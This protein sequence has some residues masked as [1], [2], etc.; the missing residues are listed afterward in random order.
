MLTWPLIVES[1]RSEQ[2]R[3]LRIAHAIVRDI[4]RGRLKPGQRL[5]G[6]R[7]LAS[8]LKVHRNTVLAALEELKGQGWLTTSPWRGTFVSTEL[9]ESHGARAHSA[10]GLRPFGLEHRLL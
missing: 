2:P 3:F 4:R 10:E 1:D 7:R 8:E 5:P 9:P 6:S